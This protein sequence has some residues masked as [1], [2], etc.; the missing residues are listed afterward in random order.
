M[1]KTIR[2]APPHSLFFISGN[3]DALSPEIT[4]TAP[5]WHN[6]FCVV[7]GCLAS[8]DGET[9]LVLLSQGEKTPPG[10][11]AYCGTIETPQ[12]VVVVSTSERERLGEIQVGS[13]ATRV[14]IWINH[15]VEPDTIHVAL[16]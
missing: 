8:Q 2:S 13:T 15:P 16:G 11:P 7:V 10:P 6:P 3:S 9:D 4:R 1:I 12:T 5:I 14:R